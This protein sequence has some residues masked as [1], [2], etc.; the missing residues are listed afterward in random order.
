MNIAGSWWHINNQIIQLVPVHISYKLSYGAACH[1][2]PPYHSIFF[3]NQQA[4]THQ[5]YSITIKRC[6]HSFFSN[7][8][9]QWPLTTNTKHDRYT[10]PVNIRIHQPYSSPAL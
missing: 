2:A 10:G 8:N 4:D 9:H 3:I 1:W 6:D 7:L 5:F